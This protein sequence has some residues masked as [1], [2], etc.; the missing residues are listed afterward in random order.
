[1]KKKSILLSLCI[2][3]LT[4]CGRVDSI[5]VENITPFE[6]EKTTEENSGVYVTVTDSKGE[7]VVTTASAETGKAVTTTKTVA[8]NLVRRTGVVKVTV[9]PSK[10]TKRNPAR[11]S[12][13]PATTVTTASGK[14]TTAVSTSG[15]TTI[16]STTHSAE[17]LFTVTR[18]DM[19]CNVAKN[20]I[21]VSMKGEPVQNIEF[22]TSFMVDSY[23]NGLTDP[24]YRINICDL[25]FDGNFD[26]FVPDSKDEHNVYGKFLRYNPNSKTF[27]K[28]EAFSGITTYTS[29]SEENGTISATVYKNDVEFEEKNYQWKIVDEKTGE[30]ELRL[31]SKKKQFRYDTENPL[32]I[33]IDYYE[34]TDSVE[35]LVKREKH[36]YDENGEFVGVQEVP[37]EWQNW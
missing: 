22:D 6:V 30:K 29:S 13:K 19:T 16:I 34:F 20:C 12:A 32:N 33:Y 25:D 7:S 24:K 14:T 18:D 36:I 5:D 26:I 8:V 11:T 2:A 31:I 15:A 37:L 35:N 10:N 3:F 17:N 4:G 23:T 28:W 1:M 21:S 9:A 27:E